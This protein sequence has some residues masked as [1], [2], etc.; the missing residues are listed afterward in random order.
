M[1]QGVQEIANSYVDQ[2]QEL[3]ER[4]DVIAWEERRL[5]KCKAEKARIYVRVKLLEFMDIIECMGQPLLG[6]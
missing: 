3:K 6:F 4:R 1:L 2:Q 5:E